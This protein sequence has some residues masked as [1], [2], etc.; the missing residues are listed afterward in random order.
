MA[1]LFSPF[2][3]AYY[4]L[5]FLSAITISYYSIPFILRF[6]RF[7]QLYDETEK[8][9]KLHKLRIP[10]LGGI[11][12]YIAA[13]TTMLMF[14]VHDKKALSSY[15]ATASVLLFVL[16]IKDDL[17]GLNAKIKL[18][19]QFI[20][21]LIVIIGENINIMNEGGYLP[22]WNL[23]YVFSVGI[24]MITMLIIVNSFNL[25]DGINGLAATIGIIVNGAFFLL[26]ICSSAF[27]LASISIIVVGSIAGFLPYNLNHVKTF[28]GD[29]GALLIGFI[30]AILSFRF[31]ELNPV[32][33]PK[34]NYSSNSLIL[35][36]A[37]MA[38]P[39]FDMC[40]VFIIRI[41]NRR[42][43]FTPDCNHIHHRMIGLGFSHTQTTV[44][45]A[46]VDILC[47]CLAYFLKNIDDFLLL[48][49][50]IAVCLVFNCIISAALHLKLSLR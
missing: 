11:A 34:S 15:V 2:S 45:L 41:I 29:T 22:G 31:I 9:R 44:A 28:M 13:I 6:A 43:P 18:L 33:S 4:I 38:V 12:I 7:W 36:V 5:I 8:E 27:Q 20:I 25:I 39:V 26:F 40:R 10:R 24:S 23:A 48:G 1:N 49:L 50:I 14:S 21:L 19:A 46:L 35:S 16:G 30:S 3:P 17:G 32:N 47:I 37:I 42:S